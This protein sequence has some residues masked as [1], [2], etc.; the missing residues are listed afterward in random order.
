MFLNFNQTQILNNMLLVNVCFFLQSLDSVSYM[1]PVWQMVFK[2]DVTSATFKGMYLSGHFVSQRKVY[3]ND[4]REQWADKI[5]LFL[6]FLKNVVFI[7][8]AIVMHLG[9]IYK[10][11]G[12]TLDQSIYRKSFIERFW[13]YFVIKIYGIL[14]PVGF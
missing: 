9:S 1:V 14:S 11:F 12:K 8:I 3:F 2:N 7:Y 13:N 4:S 10:S 6:D 5:L